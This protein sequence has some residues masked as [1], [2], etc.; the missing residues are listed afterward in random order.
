MNSEITDKSVAQGPLTDPAGRWLFYDGDC[1][2]CVSLAR[3]FTPLLAHAGFSAAPLQ[4]PTARRALGRS[5]DDPIIEM[6]AWLPNG[7]TAGGADALLLIARHTLLGWPL[8]LLSFLPGVRP[9]LRAIYR[10]IA[11]RRHCLAGG[12]AIGSRTAASEAV[13]SSSA[14]RSLVRWLPG[15][16]LVCAAFLIRAHLAAWVFMWVLAG[17]VFLG[18]KWATFHHFWIKHRSLVQLSGPA[19]AMPIGSLK[20]KF[21]GRPGWP[22]ML[23]YLFF[24]PG[25]DPRPFF[26]GTPRPLNTPSK[27]GLL[28]AAWKIVVGGA[29]FLIAAR[30]AF[31]A[32]LFRGWVGMLGIVL[33]L[34]F[35]MFELIANGFRSRGIAVESIMRHPL[36]A[37]SLADFWSRRWNTAFSQLSRELFLPVL[38]SRHGID[39]ATLGV[40]F[41]SGLLHE[42]VISVPARGGYGLPTAYFLLQGAAMLAQRNR[43]AKTVGLPAHRFHAWLFT[44]L[45]AAGPAFFL[46]HPPFI[47]RV[48]LP[49]LDA[50]GAFT[51][52]L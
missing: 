40:F 5:E 26:S 52:A 44:V 15:S 39:S 20:Q 51:K 37:T 12:C 7:Q 6:R 33:L 28:E 41:I 8:V 43:A 17:A 1:L 9:L 47:H 4:S 21:S 13:E 50:I 23:L 3:R 2:L 25:M 24:W 35:G 48:I 10:H 27:I 19:G 22:F 11:A 30:L 18:F 14:T 36:A 31:I 32:P 34:H 42:L 49:M 16:T 45:V 46:F 38:K 29:F